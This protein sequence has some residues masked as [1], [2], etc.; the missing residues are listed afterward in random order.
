MIIV[1]IVITGRAAIQIATAV[2]GSE[3]LL[4]PA[5]SRIPGLFHGARFSQPGA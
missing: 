5:L 4:A 1:T 3:A 2:S